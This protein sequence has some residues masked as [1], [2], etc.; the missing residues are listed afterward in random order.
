VEVTIEVSSNIVEILS[1][2]N[3]SGLDALLGALDTL[4]QLDKTSDM[5]TM[6]VLHTNA[7]TINS[8]YVDMATSEENVITVVVVILTVVV[9]TVAMVIIIYIMRKRHKLVQRK[10]EINLVIQ[11]RGRGITTMKKRTKKVKQLSAV[12]ITTPHQDIGIDHKNIDNKSVCHRKKVKTNIILPISSPKH[13]SK[14]LQ[15]IIATQSTQDGNCDS[16]DEKKISLNSQRDNSN[17]SSPVASSND[18]PL[19][20]SRFL[21]SPVSFQKK[22]DV[23]ARDSDDATEDLVLVRQKSMLDVSSDA[24]P[25]AVDS[26]L[27]SLYSRQR[28]K[29]Y[30]GRVPKLSAYVRR[31]HFVEHKSKSE[32]FQNSNDRRR[33]IRLRSNKNKLSTRNKD[34]LSTTVITESVVSAI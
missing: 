29:S 11:D 17:S 8:I 22:D 12:N 2:S 32:M 16:L 15:V 14:K 31:K 28:E 18:T 25:G 3:T 9:L 13:S 7:T 19:L 4:K 20:V 6:S 21:S 30:V 33:K 26:H 24:L 34:V 5:S 1:L 23:L 27:T 10:S